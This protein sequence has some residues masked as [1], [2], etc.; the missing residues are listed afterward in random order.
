MKLRPQK[1]PLARS[2]AKSSFWL[3]N[4]PMSAL[5][6]QNWNIDAFGA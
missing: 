4:W 2:P 1:I 5:K 6:R 3:T